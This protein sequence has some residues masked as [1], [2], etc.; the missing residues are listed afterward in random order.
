M[1]QEIYLEFEEWKDISS[2][3]PRECYWTVRAK[4]VDDIP[5]GLDF[6]IA[7]VWFQDKQWWV[8]RCGVGGR[9]RVDDFLFGWKISLP[10]TFN[11]NEEI[12]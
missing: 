11:I 4:N 7:Y 2:R 5:F 3:L 10:Q 9:C 8:Y 6:E 12:E 1:K